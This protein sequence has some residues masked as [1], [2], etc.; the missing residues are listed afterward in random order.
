MIYEF[1]W[2]S[3]VKPSEPATEFGSGYGFVQIFYI[4]LGQVG[5]F[6]FY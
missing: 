4:V 2:N 6:M 1:R 5:Y 3:A